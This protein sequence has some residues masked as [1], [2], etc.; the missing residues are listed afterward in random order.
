VSQSEQKAATADLAAPAPGTA[1]TP[2]QRAIDALKSTQTES[3]LRA[4]ALASTDIVAVL[5][6]DGRAQAHRIGMTLKNARVAVEKRGKEAREDAVAFSKAVVAEEKRLVA[7]VAPEEDRVFALRDGYDEKVAAAKAEAERIAAEIR[8]ALRASISII[9]ALPARAA[10][11]PSLEIFNMLGQLAARDVTTEGFGDL[12]GEAVAAVN[13]AGTELNTMYEAALLRERQQAEQEAAAAIEKARQEELAEANRKE[14]ARL[15]ALQREHDLAEQE[16]QRV[17]AETKRQLEAQAADI[18]AKRKAAEAEAQ[19]ERD[20]HAARVAAF[21]AAQ[22][23][24]LDHAEALAMDVTITAERAEAAQR[25][26][27][28]A[29]AAVQQAAVE[30]AA[31]APETALQVDPD[32]AEQVGASSL[33][34]LEQHMVSNLRTAIWDLMGVADIALVRREMEIAIADFSMVAA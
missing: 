3:D 34:S 29:Q 27:E 5:D 19:A 4:L 22:Q 1:L 2:I 6:P 28:A 16:R 18:E 20:A 26:A 21:E 8:A 12:T 31:T 17:A 10:G 15:A 14:A 32:P 23:K 25:A 13:A 7:L 11:K 30:S 33:D 9:V 24:E